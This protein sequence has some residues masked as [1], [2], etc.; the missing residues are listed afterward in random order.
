ME[1]QTIKEFKAQQRKKMQNLIASGKLVNSV[2]GFQYKR[3]VDSEVSSADANSFK[4]RW[5]K[6]L[7]KE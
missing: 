5:E 4:K 2:T 3:S 6:R 7:K 1:I